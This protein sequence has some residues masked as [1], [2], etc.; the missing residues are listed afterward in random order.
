MKGPGA[1]HGNIGG[2]RNENDTD[3][4]KDIWHASVAG[5]LEVIKNLKAVAN[6]G[7]ERNPDAESNA[8][9]A[10][11]LGGLIYALTKDL[12]VDVGVKVGLTEPEADYTILA[13]MALKF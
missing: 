8:D 4:R 12:S 6:V 2:M 9:A 13:G 7:I 5:E 11:I 1:V 3:E 10:F